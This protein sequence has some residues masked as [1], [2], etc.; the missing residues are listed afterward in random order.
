[1]NF[2]GGRENYAA[3]S[4]VALIAIIEFSQAAFEHEIK[5]GEVMRMPW[6]IEERRMTGFRSLKLGDLLF[7]HVILT[8]A[9]HRHG[10]LV[11]LRLK[12][13]DIAVM[14]PP[15]SYVCDCV[16]WVSRISLFTAE[17]DHRIDLR[18]LSCRN[19]ACKQCDHGQ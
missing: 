11:I 12:M 16:L 19:P 2:T 7:A 6:D 18:C 13:F 1:M 3:R 14:S 17:R 9:L 5:R 8:K 15:G 10:S 4:E